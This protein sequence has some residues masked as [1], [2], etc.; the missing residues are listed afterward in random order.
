MG[1]PEP[2]GLLGRQTAALTILQCPFSNKIAAQ[3]LRSWVSLLCVSVPRVFFCFFFTNRFMYLFSDTVGPN[4][5]HSKPF[6]FC[7]P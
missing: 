7:E 4:A 3:P 6:A 2:F 1:L 5:N